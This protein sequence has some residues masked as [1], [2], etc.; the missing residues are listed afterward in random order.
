MKEKG[1][2]EQVYTLEKVLKIKKD[3]LTQADFLEEV[4]K[5]CSVYPRCTNVRFSMK[6][7]ASPSGRPWP[8]LSKLRRRTRHG[9][10]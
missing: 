3:P 5:V 8:K 1:A 4:M 6:N 7:P 9:V 2:N 10:S